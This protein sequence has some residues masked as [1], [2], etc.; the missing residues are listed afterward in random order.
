MHRPAAENAARPDPQRS[1]ARPSSDVVVPIMRSPLAALERRLD[2]MR[3]WSLLVLRLLAGAFLAWE[4]LDNLLDA[5]RMGEFVAFVAAHGFPWPAASARLS[6]VLQFLIGAG[7]VAG[8]AVRPLGLLCTVHFAIAF[9]V[10]HLHDP[11]RAAWPALALSAIGLV[12]ACHG[13]GGWRR[14]REVP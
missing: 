2:A 3:P 8:I 13:G 5:G 1:Q 4:V 14:A 10:V 6:V 7:W 9:G 12:L 11:F